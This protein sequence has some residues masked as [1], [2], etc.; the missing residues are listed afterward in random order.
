MTER[1]KMISGDLYLAS[2]PEL[3]EARIRAR[4]LCLELDAVDTG[5][6]GLREQIARRLL[7]AAGES[8][9][10]EHGF[11]CDYGDNIE[12]GDRFYMNFGG[13]VLDCAK[14]V[15]GDDVKCGPNVQLITAT[16]PL[17]AAERIAGPEFAKPITI[18]DRVWLGAGV[19][20]CPGVTIGEGSTAAAGAVVTKDVPPHTLVAGVPATVKRTL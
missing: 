20:V 4:R 19:I 7:G 2:D 3:V 6:F 10:L 15:I 13:I 17:D 14:V 12:V 18:G 5:D 16:H 8:P 11:R 1:E 9:Y